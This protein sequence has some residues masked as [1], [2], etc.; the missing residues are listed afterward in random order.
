M[1]SQRMWH[2]LKYNRFESDGDDRK[3]VRPAAGGAVG[4]TTGPGALVGMI[5]AFVGMIGAFVGMI[6]AFVGSTARR[7]GMSYAYCGQYRPGVGATRGI[8][9]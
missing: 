7:R 5:G 3:R 8:S 2:P 6:G 1:G 4:T 9:Q